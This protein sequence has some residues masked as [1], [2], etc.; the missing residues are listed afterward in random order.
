MAMRRNQ[1]KVQAKDLPDSGVTNSASFRPG[2]KRPITGA[3]ICG[4]IGTAMASARKPATRL[5]PAS[6]RKRKNARCGISADSSRGFRGIRAPSCGKISATLKKPRG[7]MNFRQ[8]IKLFTAIFVAALIAL[9]VGPRAART[10][11]D[12][13]PQKQ[14]M[15]TIDE[16]Q[17]KSTLVTK[18]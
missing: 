18:E 12:K 11:Q 8:T 1:P 7:T 4:S 9:L 6:R 17:P 10:Q 15:P 13:A 16:Y 2:E 3:T 5:S 14:Q